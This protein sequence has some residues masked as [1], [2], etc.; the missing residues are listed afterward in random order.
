MVPVLGLVNE[1]PCIVT[2]FYAKG[3]LQAVLDA[4]RK[5]QLAFSAL[6]RIGA[7]LDEANG[8]AFLHAQSGHLDLKPDN[9][10][11]Q[12]SPSVSEMPSESFL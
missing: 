10:E 4:D 8:I 6:Q 5:S 11:G 9:V 3:S 7:C 12:P 1:E 2:P